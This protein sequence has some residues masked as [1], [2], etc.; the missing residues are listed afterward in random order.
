M[1]CETEIAQAVRERGRRLTIQRAKILSALRHANVHQVNFPVAGGTSGHLLGGALA[2]ILLGPWAAII[3]MTAV[4]ALQALLF[5][6]GGLAALGVNTLNMAV[7]T[8]LVTWIIYRGLSP[9][10]RLH[11]AVPAVT[12][13]T[14]AW[15]SVEAAA[16]ATGLQLAVS[17]TSPLGVALP[18]LVGVHALNRHRRGRDHARRARPRAR[19]EAGPAHAPGAGGPRSDASPQPRAAG[20]RDRARATRRLRARPRAR[21]EAGP[22]HAPGA[23]GSVAMRQRNLALLAGG[24][25]LALLVVFALAPN[26]SAQPDGLERVAEDEGFAEQAQDARISLLPDYTIP[27]VEDETLSTVLAGVTGVLAVAAIALLAG[28]ALRARS[29]RRG[30]RDAADTAPAGPS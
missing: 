10:G 27:G 18:A 12:A 20:R 9:L 15:L 22:A 23:G 11:P 29:S 2:A 7:L 3:V 6:D 21:G 4:V 26:A 5:Q 1:S 8:V 16:V 30:R 17:G 25:A 24:I 28:W 13:F 19:G 14:A